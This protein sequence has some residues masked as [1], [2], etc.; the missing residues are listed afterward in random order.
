MNNQ[1]IVTIYLHA[2][3]ICSMDFYYILY[4]KDEEDNQ[5]LIKK[6]CLCLLY[7]F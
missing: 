2:C 3:L 4:W 6:S 1:K 5:R 7:K